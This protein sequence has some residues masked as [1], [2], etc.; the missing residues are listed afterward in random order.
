[1]SRFGIGEH[2]LEYLHPGL[3]IGPFRRA[4]L[5]SAGP[6]SDLVDVELGRL[7]SDLSPSWRRAIIDWFVAD[8]YIGTLLAL[9][10]E[11]P[12]RSPVDAESTQ[13]KVSV[14]T[15]MVD[16]RFGFRCNLAHLTILLLDILVLREYRR[17]MLNVLTEVAHVVVGEALIELH[18]SVPLNVAHGEARGH[19]LSLLARVEGVPPRGRKL[20]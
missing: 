19:E 3:I 18:V 9:W 20:R 5:V 14:C 17:R 8:F 16:K 12:H 13:R 1:M 15:P 4:F 11:G 10:R 7:F 6:G 2:V